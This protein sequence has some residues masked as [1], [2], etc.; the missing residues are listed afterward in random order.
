MKFVSSPCFFRSS[1]SRTAG[2]VAGKVVSFDQLAD[3]AKVDV[4]VVPSLFMY[5]FFLREM[6]HTMKKNIFVDRI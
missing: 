2:F 5:S 1:V 4:R 3:D 6:K